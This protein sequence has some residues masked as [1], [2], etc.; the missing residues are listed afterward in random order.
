MGLGFFVLWLVKGNL[1]FCFI[2]VELLFGLIGGCSVF[3]LYFCFVYINFM[4]FFVL[5][6]IL[7]SLI[8]LLIGLEILLL[9]RILKDYYFI[10]INFFNVLLLDYLGV[11][12]VILFFLFILLLLVGVFYFFLLFG[13]VN[14]GLGIFN[15]WFLRK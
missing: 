10:E 11:L 3:L 6:I 7:I 12:I 9:V 8:G 5:M 13:L 15:F 2:E 4:V 14:V 1:L